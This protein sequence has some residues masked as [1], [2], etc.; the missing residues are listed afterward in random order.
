MEDIRGLL[1]KN[2]RELD[3]YSIAFKQIG[4]ENNS[5]IGSTFSIDKSVDS[6]II[7]NRETLVGY[8]FTPVGNTV[9]GNAIDIFLTTDLLKTKSVYTIASILIQL[10]S[11]NNTPENRIV[12]IGVY[13]VNENDFISLGLSSYI[14]NRQIF[15]ITGFLEYVK[16]LIDKDMIY[17]TKTDG[18]TYYSNLEND[19]SLNRLI[20]EMIV[21]ETNINNIE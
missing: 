6:I 14:E 13:I 10:V 15:S 5:V 19:D 7:N 9:N 11:I 3:K 17:N 4:I 21:G 20:E 16:I 2:T 12:D 1:V 18:I 8:I